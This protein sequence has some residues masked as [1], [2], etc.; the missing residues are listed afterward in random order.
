MSRTPIELNHILSGWTC[1]CSGV[2][3]FS[4]YHFVD[5]WAAG[6]GPKP[7]GEGVSNESSNE[8]SE[9]WCS[10]KVGESIGGL[11]QGHV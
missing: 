7:A 10:A 5:N 1:K 3:A 9:A 8:W 2:G 6:D 4:G 11:Y